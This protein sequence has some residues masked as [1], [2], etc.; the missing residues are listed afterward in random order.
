MTFRDIEVASYYDSLVLQ[1][2][3]L[4]ITALKLDAK[5][6]GRIACK[7]IISMPEKDED[8]SFLLAEYSMELREFTKKNI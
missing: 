4:S 3:S 2:Y 8:E 1:Y 5:E 7:K 6:L